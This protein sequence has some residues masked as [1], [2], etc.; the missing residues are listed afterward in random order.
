MDETK[1]NGTTQSTIN[2]TRVMFTVHHVQVSILNTP[3]VYVY[4][5]MFS[6]FA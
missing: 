1:D 3:L 5:G 4:I 6:V 2:H